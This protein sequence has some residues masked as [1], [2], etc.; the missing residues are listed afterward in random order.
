MISIKQD[1]AMAASP[2]HLA[3][4]VSGLNLEKWQSDFVLS[5]HPRIIMNCPRGSGKS[6]L[7]ACIALHHALNTPNAFVLMFSRSERQSME[8]F[9]KVLLYYK[10]L[11]FHP[12]AESAHRLELPNGSRI[13]SLPS[14]IETVLGFH[15]V[16]LLVIDEA[17]LVSDL[18]YLRARPML[19]HET[20]R[21]IVLSTPFG[22]RGF[23]YKEWQDFKEHPDTTIWHGIGVTTDECPYMTKKFLA[24]ER[25]K[26]GE[27]AYQREYACKFEE[28]EDSVFRMDLVRASFKDFPELDID[29]DLDDYVPT[30]APVTEKVEPD[31]KE[32]VASHEAKRGRLDPQPL[33]W[34]AKG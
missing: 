22:Q 20:G 11:E 33:D 26:L 27:R 18:L 25:L 30:V 4:F 34:F 8:L 2:V 3:R 31:K 5:S 23:F 17:A 13:L 24:E 32:T 19:N 28:N 15:D 7:T 12:S 9:R 14:S 29:L 6:M 1:L 16:T 10:R 21:L